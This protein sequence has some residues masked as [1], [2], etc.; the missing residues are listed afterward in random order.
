M[1]GGE[2]RG[3]EEGALRVEVVESINLE[4]DIKARPTRAL[5]RCCQ[6]CQT[7]LESGSVL[8]FKGS[9]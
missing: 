4:P 9:K 5:L 7:I 6:K 3:G 2:K 1:I 8:S